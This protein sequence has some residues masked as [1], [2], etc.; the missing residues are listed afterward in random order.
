MKF[1]YI[2]L[3]ALVVGASLFGQGLVKF[4]LNQV[5][6]SNASQGG[7]TLMVTIGRTLANPWFWSGFAAMSVGAVLYFVLLY[8]ADFTRALPIMGGIAY[9]VIPVYGHFV[10]KESVTIPQ[11][12]GLVLLIAG[13]LL[14]RK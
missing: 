7:A 9:L 14:L 12:A 6:A 3:A 11:L 8:F 1:S 4:A 13:I 10:L 2:A 5:A